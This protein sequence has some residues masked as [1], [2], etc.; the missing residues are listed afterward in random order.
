MIILAII[1]CF[2]KLD[3]NS[4]SLDEVSTIG[5]SR[6]WKLMWNI[7]WTQEGNMWFYSFIMY[8]WLKL[9]NSEFIIRSL[10]AIFAVLTIPVFY[11][12]AENVN[13]EKTAKI[14]TFL[15][16]VNFYFIFYSQ[17]ARGYSLSL[18]LVAL[19]SLFFLK[20]VKNPLNNKYLILHLVF[21]VLAIYTYLLSG[22]V[23][24][25]WYISTLFISRSIFWKKITINFGIIAIC[26]LPL[27]ISPAFR[28]GHQIDWLQKPSLVHLPMGIVMLGGDSIFVTFLGSLVVAFLLWKKRDLIFSKNMERFL[29]IWL[30][31]WSGFPILFGFLFSWVVKPIYEPES[32]NTS[33]PGFI[34]LIAIGL[35]QIKR[36]WLS[37]LIFILL[38]A[39]SLL[40][41]EAW[42][43]G[44]NIGHFVLENNNSRD[45][46]KAAEYVISHG[47]TNDAIISYA[48]YIRSPFKYYLDKINKNSQLDLIEISSDK[49]GIGG[50]T[51]LP[52]PNI[53]LLDNLSKSHKRIWLVLSYND[54]SWLER[55]SQWK[56]IEKELGKYYAVTSDIKLDEIEI[57]LL[58]SIDSEKGI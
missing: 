42:Y 44:E 49:Y 24:G 52:G 30:V 17:E 27:L 1:L 46:R 2:L 14:A 18:L 29:L 3:R 57:K 37:R 32:F 47:K 31:L 33:L 9:G 4:M 28:G 51:L 26:L 58:D 50:G 40:R 45:W 7:L 19:S 16:T 10:S 39:F 56:E 23:I 11:K 15:F 35:V 34:L 41:L 6:D 25:A 48:Y 36:K 53:R 5:I 38:L 13:G 43:A 21:S 54:F 22:L 12:L 8:F 55:R 20:F